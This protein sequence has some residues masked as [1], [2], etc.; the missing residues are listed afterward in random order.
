[1]TQVPPFFETGAGGAGE[2]VR[3][4]PRKTAKGES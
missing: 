1:M 2:S 3:L 4:P